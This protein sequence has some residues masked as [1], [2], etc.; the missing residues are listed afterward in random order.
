L[1][2]AEVS[3]VTDVTEV[4]D[5]DDGAGADAE[6]EPSNSTLS[7]VWRSLLPEQAIIVA[8]TR[9][10]GKRNSSFLIVRAKVTKRY[11]NGK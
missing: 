6:A 7:T 2:G 3:D 4:A 5:V 1:E 11:S 8:I 10:I 9:V